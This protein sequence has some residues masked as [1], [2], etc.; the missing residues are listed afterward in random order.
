MIVL[1]DLEKKTFEFQD[2]TPFIQG[3]DTR[4]VIHVGVPHDDVDE[5]FNIQIAYVLQNGRTTIKMPNTSMDDDTT[6]YNDIAYNIINFNL[7]RVAT[8]LSGNLVATIVVNTVDGETI[9]FNVINNVLRSAE[10]EALEEAFAGEEIPEALSDMES[11]I[12]TLQSQMANRVINGV[13]GLTLDV[14]SSAAG[15]NAHI[16]IKKDS[17]NKEHLRIESGNCYFDLG[18]NSL[19]KLLAYLYSYNEAHIIAL[20][21]IHFG[22]DSYETNIIDGVGVIV[23]D[24]E[25]DL[26][27]ISDSAIYYKIPSA[28]MPNLLINVS[29]LLLSLGGS[30]PILSAG[31]SLGGG[32][33]TT[34][35]D[36]TSASSVKLDSSGNVV[37]TPTLSGKAMIGSKEIATKEYAESITYGNSVSLAGNS[38]TLTTE[39][40]NILF[41][42][43]YKNPVIIHNDLFYQLATKTS[44]M[45]VFQ[46]SS[47]RTRSTHNQTDEYVISLNKNNDVWSWNYDVI[48]TNNEKIENKVNTWSDNTNTTKYPTTQLVKS[49]LD[50]KIDKTSIEDSTNSNDPAKVLSA[51]QGNILQGEIDAINA[52]IGSAAASDSDSVINRIK[53]IYA[54]LAGE[55]D[56]ATLLQ[57]LNAK[58]SF[59]DLQTGYVNLSGMPLA[60]SVG[61]AL[62][63]RVSSL[64]NAETGIE[65]NE[66]ERTETFAEWT[67]TFGGWETEFGT[68][69]DE[70]DGKQ[71]AIT[72]SNKLASDLVDDTNQTNKFV[73]ASEKAQITTNQNNIASLQNNFNALGLS[74]VNGCLCMTWEE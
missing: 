16:K 71:D 35:L 14:S 11:S 19:N 22:T 30:V 36:K 17:N 7:P 73:S 46:I 20:D 50:A 21:K 53:D 9:K 47:T 57:L 27:I 34:L 64:E 15:G 18:E 68:W 44:S 51:K 26:M 56:D 5:G 10:F 66:A 74:V 3:E 31:L 72:S 59:T 6:T 54:F 42:G 28:S 23:G 65:A 62:D 69:E 13:N 48:E 29:N 55:S 39:Q 63:I 33:D 25:N 60:A 2:S 37:L 12:T 41:S 67:E 8:S 32:T 4:N 40:A 49:S 1:L 61:Y 52:L 38:G 70:I 45:A 43:N 24:G 58:M